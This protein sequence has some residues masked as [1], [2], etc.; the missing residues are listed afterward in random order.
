[1]ISSENILKNQLRQKGTQTLTDELW[2]KWTSQ[3]LQ[4]SKSKL[5]S[6][7]SLVVEF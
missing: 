4:A 5:V 1:M 2:P 7:P 3:E 6:V